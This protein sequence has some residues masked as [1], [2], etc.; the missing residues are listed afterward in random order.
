VSS[1]V[2]PIQLAGTPAPSPAET[3][4]R[5]GSVLRVRGWALWAVPRR[6]IA[7]L[8]GL[9]AAAV[10]LVAWLWVERGVSWHDLVVLALLCAVSLLTNEATDR[11]EFLRRALVAQPGVYSGHNSVACFAGLLVL[12][13]P[14]AVLQVLVMYAHTAYRYRRDQT[15]PLYRPVWT[16][17]TVVYGTIAAAEVFHNLHGRVDRIKFPET[18]VLALT[19]AVYTTVGLVMLLVGM[20]QAVRT[21]PFRQLLPGRSQVLEEQATL[22]I[23]ILTAVMIKDAP[24]LAPVTFLLAGVLH[25]ASLVGALQEAATVDAKTGLLNAAA[26]A[27]RAQTELVRCGR[28]GTKASLLLVDID[29]FK[30]VNDEHGHLTGD[31]VLAAVG[32]ALRDELRAVDLLGRF[33]G[34]EFAALLPT[35]D[36]AVA[37]SAA[38]RVRARIASMPLTSGISITASIGVADSTGLSELTELLAAAD[39]ALYR[40]KDAGRDRVVAARRDNPT[41]VRG[42]FAS[43]A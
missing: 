34:E 6:G 15:G 37:V 9:E 28:E 20:R 26:W 17:T 42:A 19:L 14:A 24:Y 16:A 31:V 23:G 27:D 3:A 36:L 38:Q 40:A 25:R 2:R 4:G 41:R 7:T 22:V 43:E 8:V 13:P 18:G 5:G 39:R 12:P 35:T 1:A 33:G 29:H 32:K 10:P 30:A 11:I 21:V